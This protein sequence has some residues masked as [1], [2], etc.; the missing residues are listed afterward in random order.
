[1]WEGDR[2]RRIAERRIT[3]MD[4]EAVSGWSMVAGLGQA[5]RSGMLAL[6]LSR[7]S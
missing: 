1:V 2:R 3:V 4:A 5:D 6:R 7:R